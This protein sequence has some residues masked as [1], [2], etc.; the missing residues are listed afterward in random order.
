MVLTG[1]FDVEHARNAKAAQ[2]L[3]L[4]ARPLVVTLYADQLAACSA[5]REA[6]GRGCLFIGYGKLPIGHNARSFKKREQ[7]RTLNLDDY[8][9]RDVTGEDL[10][11][12]IWAHI[13]SAIRAVP[14]PERPAEGTRETEE[15]TWTRILTSDATLESF[16]RLL[17][18]EVTPAPSIQEGDDPT[19]GELLTAKVSGTSLKKILT[20]KIGG[21]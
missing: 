21:D 14:K 4:D 16:G 10:G 3:I 9:D 18:K 17:T 19:W 5:L 13:A 8:I 20:K 12:V 6:I 2:R 11:K 15:E 1:R 7:I